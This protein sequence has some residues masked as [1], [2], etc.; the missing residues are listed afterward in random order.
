VVEH[1]TPDELAGR[2]GWYRRATVGTPVG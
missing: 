2:D 1:G